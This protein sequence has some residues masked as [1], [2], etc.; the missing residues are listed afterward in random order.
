MIREYEKGRKILKE[1][2]IMGAVQNV[3]ALQIC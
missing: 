1:A 3:K 2:E